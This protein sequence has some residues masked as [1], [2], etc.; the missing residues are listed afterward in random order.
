MAVGL[1][2]QQEL[3]ILAGTPGSSGAYTQIVVAASAPTLYLSNVLSHSWNGRTGSIQTQLL[4]QV[5][6]MGLFNQEQ[7]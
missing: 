2:I 3:H 1:N 7:K 6:L 5:I 4:D